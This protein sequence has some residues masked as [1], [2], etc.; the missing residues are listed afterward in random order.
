MPEE[1]LTVGHILEML[2]GYPSDA[3]IKVVDPMP[4]NKNN[5]SHHFGIEKVVF[6][7]IKI[8]LF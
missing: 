1:K 4:W 6:D 3:I 7:K 2:Q 5:T 8:Q